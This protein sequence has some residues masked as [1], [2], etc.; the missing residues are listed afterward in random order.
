MARRAT[1]DAKEAM[2]AFSE[3]RKPTYTGS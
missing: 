3:K 2:L 1:S